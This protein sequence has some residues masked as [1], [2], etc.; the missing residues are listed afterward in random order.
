MMSLPPWG[1]TRN[2]MDTITDYSNKIVRA[3]NVSGPFNIQFIVKNEEVLVIEANIRASKIYAFCF[4]ICTHK[5]YRLI[6][7][8]NVE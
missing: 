2:I 3:L 1:L 4:K 6:R 8:S 7:K 5:S